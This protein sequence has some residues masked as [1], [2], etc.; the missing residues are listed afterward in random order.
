[1]DYQL[2]LT[3]N[4]NKSLKYE[5]IA[6]KEENKTLLEYKSKYI[7]EKRKGGLG[8]YAENH[9]LK[10]KV[11]D[12]CKKELERKNYPSAN[13]L[14]N[15]IAKQVEKNHKDLLLGFAPYQIHSDDGGGWTNGTFYNWCNANYKKFK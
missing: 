15:E 6:I 5:L 12:L 9:P 1:M 3:Q 2:T 7:T 14:C 10:N 13:Q 4:E 8:S 11:Q